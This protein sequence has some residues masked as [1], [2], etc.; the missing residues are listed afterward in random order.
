[1]QVEQLIE[2]IDR[3]IAAKGIA[4]P[5]RPMATMAILSERMKTRIAMDDDLYR[6]VG[7]WYDAKY[8]KRLLV[9]AVLGRVPAVFG[10][11]VFVLRLSPKIEK[12]GA[13]LRQTAEWSVEG[14]EDLWRRLDA[15]SREMALDI[16]GTAYNC[17]SELNPLV[18]ER[19]LPLEATIDVDTAI[20]EL[21]R[22][23]GPRIGLSKWASLQVAEKCLK[24]FLRSQGEQPKKSHNLRELNAACVKRGLS[25]FQKMSFAGKSLID[26]ATCSPG[27]RYSEEN[28]PSA[29]EAVNSVHAALIIASAV[30][31]RMR[32]SA[33]GRRSLDMP[34]EEAA[35]FIAE[36]FASASGIEFSA[37]D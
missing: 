20:D 1:M 29:D 9:G 24:A 33:G 10:T 4:I 13:G 31:A 34:A 37:E 19:A 32:M 28:L 25:D 7:R 3:E 27:I 12:T 6:V 11:D 16:L 22:D 15:A 2:E 5:Y 18:A 30:A 26:H 35:L 17:F 14:G 21:V 23:D 8:G 36:R